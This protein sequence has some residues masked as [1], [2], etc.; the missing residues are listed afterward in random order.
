MP[1]LCCV[2]LQFG[3]LQKTQNYCEYRINMSNCVESIVLL[4]R[5]YLQMDCSGVR[6]RTEFVSSRNFKEADLKN[7]FHFLEDVLQSKDRAKRT[8]MQNC[9]G[10]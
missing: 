2:Y 3:M 9:G 7:D 5:I 4:Q 6:D 10:K 8:L 1:S